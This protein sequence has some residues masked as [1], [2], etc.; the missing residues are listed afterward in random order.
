MNSASIGAIKAGME[1]SWKGI[2]V[3]KD[4]NT[5]YELDGFANSKYTD[6]TAIVKDSNGNTLNVY[7]YSIDANGDV[8]VKLGIYNYKLFIE[9]DCDDN[10]DAY[11]KDGVWYHLVAID[12]FYLIEGV[13]SNGNTYS[14]DGI[15]NVIS[16]SEDGN[17][18]IAYEYEILE[19]NTQQRV[20]TLRFTDENG[21]TYTVTFDYKE[22]DN[23][24]LTIEQD[25]E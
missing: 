11:G 6:A 9:C 19:N 3:S 13:D 8:L 16:T 14:F 17:T 22:H 2:Y 20:Y 15:G 5:Y 21:N 18:V 1:D 23:Y 25:E 7:T 4:G 24:V 10:A 12:D